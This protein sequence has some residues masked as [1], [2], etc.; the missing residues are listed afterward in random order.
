[1]FQT[2][3]REK[4]LHG[5]VLGIIGS[6]GNAATRLEAD[7]TKTGVYANGVL[8]EVEQLWER[9]ARETDRKK[10]EALLHRIQDVLAE[11]VI[12]APIYE[13]G[14]IWG[15]GPR[16]EQAGA[17]LIPGFADSAPVEDL[18]LKRGTP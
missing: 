14:F 7:V 13:L 17:G 12:H 2:A 10:R 1:A 18:A 3:W 6:A 9:Q 16:V 4:K 15:V 8:P 11:Q 5:V